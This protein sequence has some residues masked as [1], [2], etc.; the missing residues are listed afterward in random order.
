MSFST[1]PYEIHLHILLH[2]P[3]YSA[4][5]SLLTAY[6][7]LQ[8]IL[9]SYPHT[10]LISILHQELALFPNSKHGGRSI[11]IHALQ[12]VH[13]RCFAS[14]RQRYTT[15]ELP[16]EEEVQRRRE[17]YARGIEYF[18][19]V[20]R[21]RIM[22]A[23]E[24]M[25]YWIRKIGTELEGS[26]WVL[27]EETV[28]AMVEQHRV[29]MEIFDGFVP[30]VLRQVQQRRIKAVVRELESLSSSKDRRH[31]S[32]CG[33]ELEQ[34]KI[35]EAT[36]LPV[37][38]LEE[39]RIV[40]AVYAL[41]YSV[42]LI[43]LGRDFGFWANEMRLVIW[44][45]YDTLWQMEGMATMYSYLVRSSRWMLEHE[46]PACTEQCQAREKM[47]FGLSE[48][49]SQQGREAHV[50]CVLLAAGI[51]GLW[52]QR[53]QVGGRK[54]SGKG[55]SDIEPLACPDVQDLGLIKKILISDYYSANIPSSQVGHRVHRSLIG[56][57]F[58]PHEFK[59]QDARTDSEMS[60]QLVNGVRITQFVP[61]LRIAAKRWCGFLLSWKRFTAF[62]R[63]WWVNAA[64]NFI[65]K[66]IAD[67]GRI[68]DDETE[69]VF[70]DL[71]IWDDCR[72]KG[73]QLLMPN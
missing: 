28:S 57:A 50:D 31:V 18:E 2:V 34:E 30:D 6:P 55:H 53:V 43:R 5:I 8:P 66:Y 48:E 69:S 22:S 35:R 23:E 4:L 72:L 39:R 68:G 41:W 54:S 7:S 16:P 64:H 32:G 42:D 10:I 44:N 1:L 58:Y 45:A 73:W 47:T 70:V 26:R 17:A 56:N 38:E 12:Q 63:R 40:H 11:L 46:L 59:F 24:E 15:G 62:K 67:K 61:P 29:V 20:R 49:L 60:G 19:E 65:S 3:T 51:E 9:R 25:R 36:A 52:S 27:S 21:A 71:A 14:Q 33:R 37:S 13:I